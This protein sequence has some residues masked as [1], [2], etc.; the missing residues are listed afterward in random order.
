M[1]KIA[2]VGLGNMGLPMA[3]NLVKAG[4]QVIGVDLSPVACEALHAAGGQVATSA[5]QAADGAE[6]LITML[7]AGKHVRSV[8]L[9]D[10]GALA[11]LAPDALAIDSSTIDVDTARALHE[12]ASLR[13]V[14]FIDAPVSGGT[15][16]AQN[17]TLTFMVGGSDDAVARA[18]PFLQQMGKAVIHA[19]GPGNGQAAKLCNN[20]MLGIQMLSVAEGFALADRL[21]LERQKLFDIASK[22]SGACWSLTVNCPVPGPVPT[23]PANRGYEG[24]FFTE[25][26]L[27]DMRL[28]QD[29]GASAGAATPLAAAATQLYALAAQAG[30][31]K[32]DFSSLFEFLTAK[33]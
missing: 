6:L 27:K 32:K 33:N 5:A 8:L 12:A 14:S 21:G 28:A 26:M 1:A 13:H 23:S 2:F 7:P 11:K 16:G 20:M 19:G 24:G 30:L 17:A 10:D 3:Q 29:A 31:A 15:V 22:S 25:L 4:H 9:G 18:T